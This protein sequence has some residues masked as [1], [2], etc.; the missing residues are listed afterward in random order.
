MSIALAI[1]NLTVVYNSKP[2]LWNVSAA[3]PSGILLAIVG[4]NGAGKSTLIK[5]IVELV[6]P[7]HGTITIFGQSY[8]HQRNHIAYVPQRMSIDWDFPITV[9]DAVLMGRYGHLSLMARPTAHDKEI[10][11][12]ALN[13]VDMLAYAYTP[14]NAL[15]GGQ[16]Q[17]VFL[18]RAL[19]QEAELY[20]MDEP[21]VG[22]DEPT[23]KATIALLKKLRS[24]GKTIIIVHHDLH[25]MHDYF[26]WALVLNGKALACGPLDTIGNKEQI[27]AAYRAQSYE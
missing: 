7:T 26:D 27:R 16:Q 13:A 5:S 18:A 25:T 10:A 15:S 22:L 24:Q 17:R 2:V 1:N 8:A 4:P 14:I 9:F 3:I 6:K 11:W 20:L 23:E 12:N 21:F 19:T